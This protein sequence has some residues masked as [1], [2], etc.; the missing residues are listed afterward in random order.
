MP[1]LRLA[2]VRSYSLAGFGHLFARQMAGLLSGPCFQPGRMA[3]AALNIAIALAL[4]LALAGRPLNAQTAYFSGTTTTAVGSG[5]S[6]PTGVA[7]D[8]S[9]NIFVADAGNNAVKEM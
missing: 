8:G 6:L 4:P 2:P 1:D 3:R 5:F 7:V 9:G